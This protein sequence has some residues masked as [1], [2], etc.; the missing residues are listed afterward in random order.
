MLAI[1]NAAQTLNPYQHL[2]A[3][4]CSLIAQVDEALRNEDT[5][6]GE[7]VHQPGLFLA[8]SVGRNRQNCIP[9]SI[10]ARRRY[11]QRVWCSAVAHQWMRQFFSGAPLG[12]HTLIFKP[13]LIVRFRRCGLTLHS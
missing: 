9:R 6:L 5:R 10:R 7:P 8:A 13:L 1:K 12:K 2:E 3:D 4:N 11:K